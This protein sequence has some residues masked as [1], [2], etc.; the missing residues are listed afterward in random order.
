MIIDTSGF[1]DRKKLFTSFGSIRVKVVE[2]IDCLD[3]LYINDKKSNVSTT[4]YN[5]YI[6]I[7]IAKEGGDALMT[8]ST[9]M[10]TY[11]SGAIDIYAEEYLFD[12]ISSTYNIIASLYAANSTME[13]KCIGLVVIPISRLEENITVS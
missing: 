2:A 3:S 4:S 11:T 8:F 6:K 12:G 1:L 10:F 5:I 13:S 9:G 7:V